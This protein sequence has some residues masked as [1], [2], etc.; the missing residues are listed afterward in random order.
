MDR[1][2]EAYDRSKDA[3][4]ASVVTFERS[5]DASRAPIS[6]QIQIVPPGFPEHSEQGISLSEQRK[7]TYRNDEFLTRDAAL[8][9]D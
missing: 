8:V 9:R 1:S 5:F 7:C 4:D 3:L 6:D 2:C